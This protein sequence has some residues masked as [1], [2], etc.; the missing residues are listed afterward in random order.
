M[1]FP[2]MILVMFLLALYAIYDCGYKNGAKTKMK[3]IKKKK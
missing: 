2:Y 3:K 1:H